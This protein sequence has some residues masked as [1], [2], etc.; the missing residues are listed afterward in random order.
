MI[1]EYNCIGRP[2][3]LLNLRTT[4]ARLIT[5]FD[6]QQAPGETGEKVFKDSR[7]S[8]VIYW[9]ELNLIFNPRKS[10]LK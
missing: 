1:G 2:V 3:A 8:F 5:E 6:I 10:D 4:L 7:D 9:G